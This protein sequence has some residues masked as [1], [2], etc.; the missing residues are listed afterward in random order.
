MFAW[1]EEQA[2]ILSLT[3][4]LDF[5]SLLQEFF[6]QKD[7][8]FPSF[9]GIWIKNGFTNLIGACPHRVDYNIYIQ[10][11][12]STILDLLYRIA[13]CGQ[14]VL[15]DRCVAETL[16]NMGVIYALYTLYYTQSVPNEHRI[17][18]TP[19]IYRGITLTV[20]RFQLLG[21]LG[22]H[23]V[24]CFRRLEHDHAFIIAYYTGGKS[25]ERIISILRHPGLKLNL[26]QIAAANDTVCNSIN[27]ENVAKQLY[28]IPVLSTQ[29]FHSDNVL[30]SNIGN[31]EV[32]ASE[33]NRADENFKIRG[34]HNCGAQDDGA[35]SVLDNM[36]ERHSVI[37]SGSNKIGKDPVSSKTGRII[38]KPLLF[39]TSAKANITD[40]N[41]TSH[42][43]N[44]SKIPSVSSTIHIGAATS[45][46]A[47]PNMSTGEISMNDKIS[48]S[49]RGA[50]SVSGIE[51]FL[52]GLDVEDTVLSEH[53][54]MD[55]TE[56]D[57]A[58]D[59]SGN[60]MSMADMDDSNREIM[61]TGK[62][63]R[64]GVN[65]KKTKS[66]R[67][68]KTKAG[69][70][71]GSGTSRELNTNGV[72]SSSKSVSN[73]EKSEKRRKGATAKARTK[74][75]TD[76]GDA[77]AIHRKES[78]G[79]AMDQD[80]TGPPRR[81]RKRGRTAPS[82]RP[83]TESGLCPVEPVEPRV[84]RQR[85]R[86]SVAGTALDRRGGDVRVGKGECVDDLLLELERMTAEIEYGMV[87][88]SGG[89]GGAGVAGDSNDGAE[90]DGARLNF[91]GRASGMAVK[92]KRNGVRQQKVLSATGNRGSR[93]RQAAGKMGQTLLSRS[94]FLVSLYHGLQRSLRMAIL[95]QWPLLFQWT[96][97]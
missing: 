64:A 4:S 87:G 35:Y 44:Q 69:R 86:S 97:R 76:G 1:Q 9:K 56:G 88:E 94:L 24:E 54:C 33:Q 84:Q 18:I 49:S 77:A 29:K 41:N 55:T 63:D 7:L 25:L 43:E 83:R 82:E 92:R 34:N 80:V 52:L 2:S 51:A 61:E 38:R 72:S 47:R 10:S 60:N 66:R 68:T 96:V 81:T 90:E 74:M 31:N 17:R 78:D 14:L 48:P 27:M 42:N 12:Y 70:G 59:G 53:A 39:A 6:Q 79:A 71:S 65:S 57:D 11:I 89:S 16:W 32:G 21:A 37:Y 45:S 40:E 67:N 15:M 22:H 3:L 85:R 46:P 75:G 8:E 13:E 95:V 62:D 23:A 58:N 50:A 26:E 30:N 28:N 20:Q 19:D 5:E 73:Y 93:S 36:D 91:K